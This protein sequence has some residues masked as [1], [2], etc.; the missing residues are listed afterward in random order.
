MTHA[1]VTIVAPLVPDRIGKASHM[2]DALGNPAREDLKAALD[3]AIDPDGSA[4]HFA[5]LHALPSFTAGRAHLILEFSAD[6]TPA[7]VIARLVDAIGAHLQ[8]IFTLASDW[9]GGNLAAYLADHTIPSGYTYGKPA[10]IGHVGSP[11]MSVGLIRDEDALALEARKLLSAQGPG[12]APMARLVAVRDALQARFPTLLAD[13]PPAPPAKLLS[14]PAAGLKCLPN[15][16]TTFLWPL[17]IPLLL[18]IAACGAFAAMHQ[19]P[20]GPPPHPLLQALHGAW[21]GLA[22]GLPW[23]LVVLVA[24][25]LRLRW[26]ESLDWVSERFP[27]QH[28]EAEM[29]DRENHC[30]QNHMVSITRLKPGIVRRITIRLGFWAIAQ[31]GSLAYRPG[32]LGPIGTIHFARW[33]TVPGT[34]DFIFFSNYGGSWQ[35]YLED[36]ITLAHYGLTAAWSNT[37][38]FPRTSNLFLQGATDADRFKRYARQSMLPT[39]FWYSAYPTI[40]TDMIR[41]NAAIRRGLVGAMSED[42]AVAWL[43][44]FGSAT[45]PATQMVTDEIQSLVFGGMGFLPASRM[46]LWQLPDDRSKARG[47]FAE[48]A[49][50]VAYDDGRR[51]GDRVEAIV[52]LA[53][54]AP[55]L[56]ALGL[57]DAAMAS[58][59]PPFTQGMAAPARARILGDAGE[60]APERWWWGSHGEPHLA[61]ILLGHS[62]AACDVL[63]AALTAAAAARG[64]A[65]TYRVPMDR[66]DPGDNRE[67]F[68][69]VD[70]I[71]QP[72]IRGTYKGATRGDA[73][74]LVEPG[75][76]ILGYPDNRGETPPGPSVAAGLDPAGKLPVRGSDPT[77]STATINHPREIGRNGSYLVIRH[78]E[79]D[80]AAFD[81]YCAQQADELKHRLPAPYRVDAEFIAAKLLGR[82]RNGAP[83]V[84]APYSDTVSRAQAIAAHNQGAPKDA[85]ITFANNFLLGEEDPEGLRCPFGA[86]IRRANPRDS[87]NPGSTDQVAISNRHRIL[88]I[89]RK[90]AGTASPSGKP[91]LVFLCLNADIERQFEF[92]QQTW[93]Q[94]NVISLTCPISLKG[95]TDPLLGSRQTTNDSGSGYTMPSHDGL[96]R[97]APPPRFVTVR[98]GGYFFMPGRSVVNWLASPGTDAPLASTR[99]EGTPATVTS[100]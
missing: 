16:L 94:G 24:V 78:L 9:H 48:V 84:R 20:F 32:Y 29:A 87:L 54:S 51:L 58:F 3:A 79:Q 26:L 86:H 12:M 38:G 74:H 59:P 100:L 28:L 19:R 89:G 43:S 1:L 40:D 14:I 55:G 77:L 98:G 91:G 25:Y 85:H 60:D 4:T 61:L 35:A 15:L 92:V 68:G 10:G 83:I 70:G 37:V 22:T 65:M 97:L 13:T 5:S 71:S 90:Y 31:V 52:Q 95:E 75:E 72:V 8:P 7:Q 6:G 64:A 44:R 34:R 30:A 33:I 23:V 2:I 62:E 46:T 41:A 81:G 69:F 11:G 39:R 53:V 67:P 49:R 42:D 93:I 18:W 63:E 76:F 57:P 88:R 82:W 80:P 47:F 36:F 50:H 27:T 45:R 17:A 66:Y 21:H 96:I 99:P 56:R 73:L